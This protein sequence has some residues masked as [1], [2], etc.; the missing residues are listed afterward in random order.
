[1]NYI[2]TYESF[3]ESLNEGKIPVQ[4]VTY[5]NFD[6]SGW[7][8]LASD[9]GYGSPTDM[10]TQFAEDL[11]LASGDMTLSRREFRVKGITKSGKTVEISQD[12]E[13]DMYGGPYSPKMKKPVIKLG[14]TDVYSKARSE[15]EKNGD[16]P[17]K[18]NDIDATRTDLYSKLF[19]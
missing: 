18:G 13:Y 17:E 11:N 9:A 5:V 2:K 3:A 8:Y 4:T 1:M 12:G 14:G 10:A 16:S 7:N 19:Y 15:Y 6:G